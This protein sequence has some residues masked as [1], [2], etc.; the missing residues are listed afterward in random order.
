LSG[1]DIEMTHAFLISLTAAGLQLAGAAPPSQASQQAT[2][3]SK[4]PNE[5]ICEKQNVTGSRLTS[6]RVCKTRAQWADERLQD[7]QGIEKVQ[8][9]RGMSQ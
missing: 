7:R 2:P 4:D 8:V 6:K 5:V 1:E 3:S 9:E